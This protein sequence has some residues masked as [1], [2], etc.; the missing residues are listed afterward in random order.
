MYEQCAARVIHGVAPAEIHVL[1]RFDDVHEA[2]DVHLEPERT[3][4]AAEHEDVR[5]QAGRHD[6]PST[7]CAARATS[8]WLRRRNC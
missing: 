1:E 2:P 5:D 4:E 8:R 7:S 3:Q 6:R